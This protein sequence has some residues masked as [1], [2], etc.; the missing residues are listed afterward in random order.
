MLIWRRKLKL[1]WRELHSLMKEKELV[2]R[3]SVKI[4]KEITGT[5]QK[6]DCKC[7]KQMQFWEKQDYIRLWK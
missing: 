6:I 7:L 2:S 3:Q 4:A 5:S 1:I